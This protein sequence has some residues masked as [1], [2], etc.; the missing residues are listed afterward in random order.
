MKGMVSYRYKESNENLFIIILFYLFNLHI[1][2]YIY[3]D[4]MLQYAL[5]EVDHLIKCCCATQMN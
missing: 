1:Y 3:V 2:I 5:H 4:Y